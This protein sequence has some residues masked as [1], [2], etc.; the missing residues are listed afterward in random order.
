MAIDQSPSGVP[1]CQDRMWSMAALAAK[2]RRQAAA[3]MLAPRAR[4]DVRVGVPG[5]VVDQLGGVLA[6]LGVE[7]VGEL[8]GGWLPRSSSW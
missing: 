4:W 7:E 6:D 3:L 8:R 1:R 2:R 5:L